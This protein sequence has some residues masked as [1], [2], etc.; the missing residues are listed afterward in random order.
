MR[1]PVV[2][3]IALSLAVFLVFSL[4]GCGGGDAATPEDADAPIEAVALPTEELDP[5]PDLSAQEPAT[6]ERFPEGDDV[7][8]SVTERLKA[9][10]P[11]L[12]LFN[13]DA[14]LDANDLRT[15]VNRVIKNNRGMVDLL[16]YDVGKY[17]SVNS[18]GVV[19]VAAAKLGKDIPAQ[20][21]V[22]LARHLEVTFTPYILIVDD[23]GF[24]VFRHSGYIDSALLERQ[25]QRVSE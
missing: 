14:Q 12:M 1:R 25:V 6:F 5:I 24:V 16:V 17:S 19:D 21:S 11:M 23:Q 18:S 10:R 3:L 7:P 8:A 13:D 20:E 4:T 2:A 9:G 22:N 15:E